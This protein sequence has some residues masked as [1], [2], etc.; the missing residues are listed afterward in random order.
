M[1]LF[2]MCDWIIAK[3]NVCVYAVCS[4]IRK[5]NQYFQVPENNW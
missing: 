2:T 3:V 5:K 4:A 1:I